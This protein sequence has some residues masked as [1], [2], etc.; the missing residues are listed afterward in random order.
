VQLLFTG[1]EPGPTDS[2][3]V[4]AVL[5]IFDLETGAIAH[6]CDYV[7]P[8]ELRAPAQKMQFTGSAMHDGRLYVCCHNEI[9]WFDH[10]PPVAPDGRISMPGF[11]DLHH[12]LPWEGGLVVA[13]TGLET[14]DHISLAGHL[15]N[16]WD[17]LDGMDGARTIDPKVEYRRLDDREMKPHRLHANHLFAVDGLLWVTQLR[18]PGAVCVTDAS[19]GITFAAGM[20]HD[21]RYINGSLV[22]TTTNGHLVIVDPGSLEVVAEHDLRRTTPDVDV[23]GW[24]R[25]VCLDPRGPDRYCVAFTSIRDTRW[26]EYAFWARHGHRKLPS[27]IVSYNVIRGEM[28]AGFEATPAKSLVIFQL[29]V[30]PESLWV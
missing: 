20:P 25:G 17:L 3:G 1:A 21:G 19:Q 2:R 13:N 6:R 10:W 12:C 26:R 9:V 29:D 7:T 22:F 11:N 8:P 5:G 30:L 4:R 14:V 24:C 15:L 23:L 18:R 28:H 16:R 27:R